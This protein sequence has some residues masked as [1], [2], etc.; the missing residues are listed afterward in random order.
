MANIMKTLKL[1]VIGL[2]AA[3][4]VTGAVSAQILI[5]DDQR[6]E[7]EAAAY[8]DFNLQTNELR[9]NI[10][11]LRKFVTRGGVVEQK[12]A[13]LEKRK[14][15]IGNDKYEAEKHQLEQQYVKAQNALQQ[16]EYTFDK[17]RQEAMV[18]VERARQPV[19]RTILK[20]H[21]AQIIMLKRLVLGSAAGLDVTTEFIEK[22]DAQL[23]NV[24]ISLPKQGAAPAAK[25]AAKTGDQKK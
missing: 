25:P 13:D 12:L 21:K 16:L 23:P 5:V 22:L 2:V 11:E 24:T 1:A 15:I 17:L 10:L 18:Q 6:V 3:A 14:S 7:R 4:S 20:E 19:I 9:N 8:K